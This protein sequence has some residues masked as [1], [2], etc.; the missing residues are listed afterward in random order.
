MT[1]ILDTEAKFGLPTYFGVYC[2]SDDTYNILLI[3]ITG[4]QN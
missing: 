4:F 1:K 3:F 2:I